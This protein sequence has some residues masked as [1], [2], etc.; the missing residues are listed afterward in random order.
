MGKEHAIQ[1]IMLYAKLQTTPK[2]ISELSYNKIKK[3]TTKQNCEFSKKLG[4]EQAIQKI[5]VVC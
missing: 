5:I 1:K 4:K 2:Q 3:T